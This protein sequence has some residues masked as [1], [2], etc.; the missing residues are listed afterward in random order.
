VEAWVDLDFAVVYRALAG[1]DSIAQAAG[2]C[3]REGLLLDECGQP[4][5]GRVVVFVPPERPP[6]GQ[7]RKAADACISVLHCQVGNPLA[8]D[9]FERYFKQFYKTM[10]LD[11][12]GISALLKVDCR[13]T[14][15]VQFRSAADAFKLIDDANQA[16]VVVRYAPYREE[17]AKWL[18]SLERDGPER[19]LMRKLQ[20]HTV[21]IPQK[22]ADKMLAQGDLKL[23]MPGLYV[24]ADT[25]NL[26]DPQLGLRL[27]G[28]VYNPSGFVP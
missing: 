10:K 3:N 25:D 27:E 14:L 9:L 7:M 24:L 18:A 2:R 8:R 21:T 4:R 20:R 17:L 1:L 13:K 23:P 19:W 16:T 6:A 15:G 22:M 11:E 5:K 12:K 26:Y 28:D